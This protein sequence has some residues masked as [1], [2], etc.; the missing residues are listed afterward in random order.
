MP[1]QQTLAKLDWAAIAR[2]LDA[3][4]SA[5][6][7][8]IL[9][10]DQCAELIS[11]YEKDILFRSRVV[12]AR[13][14]FGKGEY[15]YFAYPL[16]KL[17]ASLRATLYERLAPIANAWEVMLGRDPRFPETHAEFLAT[18][19]AAGQARPTPLLLKYGADDYNCLHQDLYGEHVFP[20][21]AAFLLSRPNEDFTG[22]EFVLTEQRPRMQSR[23]EVAPLTQGR[24]IIFAVNE[25]PVRGTKGIYRVKMRHGV[26]RIRSGER[27][28]MGVI[29][30]DA[31]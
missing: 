16:P 17:I 26:S 31:T 27:F 29:L 19:H 23:A 3:S 18:C 1:L 28:T 4:G 15:K 14:G 11:T 8:P 6:T 9:N 12:M 24:A 22:G 5:V 13:H 25:R 21:Q 20:L 7:P 2:D 30:H 10:A